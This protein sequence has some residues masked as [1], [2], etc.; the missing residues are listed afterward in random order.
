ME[1]INHLYSSTAEILVEL[2][3]YFESNY[4]YA[5]TPQMSQYLYAGIIT[6]TN[7][8]KTHITPS[9]H[10]FLWKLLSKGIRRKAI[11]ELIIENSLNKRLFDQ[12]VI[13]N[14]KITPNG[15]AFS[16]VSAK[17]LKKYSI[18]DYVSAIS[19]LENISGI[20]I[21]VIFIEDKFLKKWK[22]S[23]RSKRLPIDKMAARLGGGGHKLIASTVLKKKREFW[24]SLLLLDDYLVKFGFSGCS[25]YGKLGFSWKLT[26]Y[27]LWICWK[28]S[29]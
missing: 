1:F 11:N 9:T 29:N 15:L 24:A 27:R 10:Y 25:D 17:L 14:I 16:I 8:L 13:R 28:Q 6:D 2:L 4:G 23:I 5:F 3:L 22:C 21:W 12:E 18:Q 7:H 19:N 26:L 20:E